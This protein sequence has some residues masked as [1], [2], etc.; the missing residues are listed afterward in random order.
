MREEQWHGATDT[1]GQ[2]GIPASTRETATGGSPLGSS[3]VSANPSGCPLVASAITQVCVC[4]LYQDEP[5]CTSAASRGLSAPTV[6]T[7][8]SV[9]RI[10]R[11]MLWRV[12]SVMREAD[13]NWRRCSRAIRSMSKGS[14]LRQAF[15]EEIPLSG[16][17]ELPPRELRIRFACVV[18][19]ASVLLVPTCRAL[20]TLQAIPFRRSQV[21]PLCGAGSLASV[22]RAGRANG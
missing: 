14:G 6:E 7:S 3:R 12:D 19:L 1:P 11:S 8:S 15:A 5:I 9:R 4:R 10:Q 18:G 17:L 13:R 16:Y 20:R 2:T 21:E 22:A